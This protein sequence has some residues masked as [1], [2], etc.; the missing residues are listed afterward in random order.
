[1]VVV[2]VPAHRW[3]WSEADEVLGHR[4]RYTRRSLRAEL[5]AAGLRPVSVSHT[6]AW[7]VGPVW[8]R[9]RRSSNPELGL[10][11]DSRFV[12]RGARLLAFGERQILRVTSLPFGTSILAVATAEERPENRASPFL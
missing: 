11:I 12:T 2:N 6:F 9:R 3:L 10:D 7:L 4:R 1:M 8:W 5:V